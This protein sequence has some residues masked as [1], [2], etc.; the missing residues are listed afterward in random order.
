MSLLLFLILPSLFL[1]ILTLFLMFVSLNSNA[2]T[3]FLILIF[4]FLL[5][6]K[7]SLIK[8]NLNSISLILFLILDIF[9]TIFLGLCAPSYPAEHILKFNAIHFPPASYLISKLLSRPTLMSK[10]R[11]SSS[12]S[13]PC[14]RWRLQMLPPSL[15]IT[16][17]IYFCTYRR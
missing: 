2:I 16:R 9:T 15:G 7:L 6:L 14:A 13:P 8:I 1:M 11:W 5:N 10:A 12:C 3:L 4:L 17:V